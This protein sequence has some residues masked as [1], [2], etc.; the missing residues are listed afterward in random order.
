M[1]LFN[2]YM[3]INYKALDIPKVFHLNSGRQVEG[4]EKVIFRQVL[5]RR[6]HKRKVT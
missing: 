6:T 2:G 1:S 3:S 5:R 4:K